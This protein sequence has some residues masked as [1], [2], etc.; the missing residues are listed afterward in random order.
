MRYD[1]IKIIDM[2][3]DNPGPLAGVRVLD[4]TAVVMGPLARRSW[5]TWAPT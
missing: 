2:D 1:R 5:A 4:L 3:V